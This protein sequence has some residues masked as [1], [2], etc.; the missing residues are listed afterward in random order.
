M[1]PNETETPERSLAVAKTTVRSL[2]MSPEIQGRFKEVL[3]DK[4]PQFVSSLINVSNSMRDV[5]PLSIVQSA[6]IAATLDLPIDRNLGFAWLVAYK[7]K[8]GTKVCQFQ[9]GFKGF[10]QLALRTAQYKRMNARALNKEA[11]GGFDEVGEP[12][13]DWSKV[14]EAKP[15]DGYV[16]AFQLVNGFTKVAYWS[17]T[18]VET[19]ARQYSQSFRSNYDSPWKSHFDQMALKTVVKNELSKWGILSIEM[20]NAMEKDQGI[21]SGDGSVEFLDNADAKRLEAGDDNV[22]FEGQTIEVPATPEPVP[23][24]PAKAPEPPPQRAKAPKAH[25][26]RKAPIEPA[27][28]PS[29]VEAQPPAEPPAPT[30]Q[31]APAA[32]DIKALRTAITDKGLTVFQVLQW[33]KANSR[34]NELDGTPAVTLEQLPE[35]VLAGLL[36]NISAGKPLVEA[37]RAMKD[38]PVKAA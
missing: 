9:M 18:R 11:I 13:I 26:T 8:G 20:Q 27:P 34:F 32:T 17:K 35:T 24:Q 1:N 2:V 10:I 16:F 37:V 6:M 30:A 15:T 12:I 21:V 31:A 19:H 29:N 38:E 25:D 14:D 28:E 22:S 5:E 36:K 23:A 3:K 4:A 33:C 7:G